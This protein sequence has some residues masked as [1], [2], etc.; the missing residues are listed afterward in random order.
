M[1]KETTLEHLAALLPV[2]KSAIP[3][4]LAIGLCDMEKFIAYWPGED[5]DLKIKPGQLLQ[6]AEPL[7]KAL[8]DDVRFQD[9]VPAQY[10]GFEFIGTAFPLHD[11]TGAVIGGLAIQIRSHSELV[12]IADRISTSLSL[13]NEQI[14]RLNEGSDQLAGLAQ[15]LHGYSQQTEINIANTDSVVS[16]IKGIADQTHLIGINAAIEAAHAGDRGAGFGVIAAEIRK[17][18]A[19]TVSSTETVRD[20]LDVFKEL[21]KT[22]T[23]SIAYIA[24]TGQGQA[25]S[26]QQL[27]SFFEEINRLSS[28]LG[29]FAKRL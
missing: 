29:E 19:Q 8:R 10:Y 9:V 20:T 11:H 12:G 17:L 5:I 13:A 25:A 2:V 28:T 7:T 16:L 1:T 6:E 27:L 18:A 26:T 23:E 3:V 24:E 15:Q 4:D 14:V 21:T 22:M